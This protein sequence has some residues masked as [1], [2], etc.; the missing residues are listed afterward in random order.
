MKL[1][2][3]PYSKRPETIVFSLFLILIKKKFGHKS[4]GNVQFSFPYFLL[5]KKNFPSVDSRT[6]I[7]IKGKDVVVF[8]VENIVT[9]KLYEPGCNKRIYNIDRHIGM[10]S[11]LLTSIKW[12]MWIY[13]L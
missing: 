3:G 1:T 9:S 10:V 7:A 5:S 13:E 6:A 11:C 12:A 8:A 2:N 4:R